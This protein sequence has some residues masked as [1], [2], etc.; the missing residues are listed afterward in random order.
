MSE[1]Q[2]NKV[3]DALGSV[4]DGAGPAP[5]PAPAQVP[6]SP[7]RPL[8][9]SYGQSVHLFL[10]AV[11][12]GMPLAAALDAFAHVGSGQ[13][14][15]DDK[16]FFPENAVLGPV[17]DRIRLLHR[18]ECRVVRSCEG[19]A[20]DSLLGWRRDCRFGVWEAFELSVAGGG[21]QRRWLPRVVARLHRGTRTA[22]RSSRRLVSQRLWRRETRGRR[23]SARW[24][25]SPARSRG[26]AGH[27][28]R[29]R[30]VSA[31]SVA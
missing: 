26:P 2:T 31:D 21:A 17:A 3:L 5:S 7:P 20:D 18:A 11:A 14:S 9:Q 24:T 25:R 1:A 22:G 30:P 12:K 23:S 28:S 13:F 4:V 6:T 8:F 16:C 15:H 29:L 19:E 10:A 27:A